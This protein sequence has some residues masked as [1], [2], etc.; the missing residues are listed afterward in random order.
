MID[1]LFTSKFKNPR[2]DTQVGLW[3]WQEQEESFPVLDSV[4]KMQRMD[5]SEV[6]D[7]DK[8]IEE[9]KWSSEPSS[10]EADI[11]TLLSIER[12][13]G[14]ASRDG[15]P[16]YHEYSRFPQKLP[17]K[18][19]DEEMRRGP[20]PA[21]PPI[22]LVSAGGREV[23][24]S[25]QPTPPLESSHD[26]RT[27]N[28]RGMAEEEPLPVAHYHYPVDSP[29]VSAFRF[30]S[31]IQVSDFLEPGPLDEPYQIHGGQA[32]AES[33]IREDPYDRNIRPSLSPQPDFWPGNTNAQVT[34]DQKDSLLLRRQRLR[35]EADKLLSGWAAKNRAPSR[36]GRANRGNLASPASPA[37]PKNNQAN[38]R[39]QDNRGPFWH[40][41]NVDDSES[42]LH[43]DRMKIGSVF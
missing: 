31:G 22:P 19:S 30:S 10:L 23:N 29:T 43:N 7:L 21:L 33:S 42:H 1:D 17:A 25:G 41:Y 3:T 37:S 11:T 40:Y 15:N 32:E 9:E 34:Q 27:H 36:R 35:K 12:Q 2:D 39:L 4:F 18:L 16:R 24:I 38:P 13:R 6:W 8:K 14:S 26:K 28:F 5:E 20:L